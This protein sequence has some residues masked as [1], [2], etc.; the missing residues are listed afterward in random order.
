MSPPSLIRNVHSARS[1]KPIHSNT[2][3][4]L[5]GELSRSVVPICGPVVSTANPGAQR[6]AKELSTF[7][8]CSRRRL[9]VAGNRRYCRRTGRHSCRTGPVSRHGRRLR[10]TG[11]CRSQRRI[12]RGILRR[13]HHSGGTDPTD[14][15]SGA[16]PV[17][18]RPENAVEQPGH[19]GCQPGNRT[20]G[21]R[22]RPG[23]H[24]RA[25]CLV[26]LP[27]H[28]QPPVS[29]VDTWIRDSG[30]APR[31]PQQRLH[32]QRQRS[33]EGSVQPFRCGTP[34]VCRPHRD[35]NDGHRHGSRR[36][37]AEPGPVANQGLWRRLLLHVAGK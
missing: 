14:R 29:P 36:G 8:C 18:C 11:R 28:G 21:F 2:D 37:G 24:P 26:R 16:K 9:G 10:H 25:V 19:H 20:P 5:T 31:F 27:Q 35:R 6:V 34:D 7:G 13:L 33:P 12:G 17:F 4:G 3:C 23:P 1:A 30:R 15:G 32:S 22:R